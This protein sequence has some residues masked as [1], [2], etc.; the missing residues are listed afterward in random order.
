MME[1]NDWIGIGGA[2]TMKD[3]VQ[4]P[5]D[6]REDYLEY[7]EEFALYEVVK[8]NGKTYILT[9]SGLPDGANRHNLHRFDAYD[10][11]TASTDYRKQ[12]FDDIFLVTGHCPTY[13]LGEKYRGRIYRKHN[14]I[15][16]DTGAA[17][18][19]AMGCLCLET[20]KEFYV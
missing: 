1:I 7:L 8:V 13:N 11:A 12:C 5:E 14:H 16:I 4:L 19:E 9:H 10:F 2:P 6:E 18:G 20:D 3:F 15:A 17:F